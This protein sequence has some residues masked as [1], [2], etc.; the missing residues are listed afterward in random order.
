VGLAAIVALPSIL[1]LLQVESEF[2]KLGREG[3]DLA[4]FDLGW[5]RIAPQL[6]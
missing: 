2:T 4:G 3:F 6:Q 5:L 1:G